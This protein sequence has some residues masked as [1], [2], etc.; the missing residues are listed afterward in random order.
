MWWIPDK[1]IIDNN[2]IDPLITLL[3]GMWVL[4]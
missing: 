3:R 1:I 4:K 2:P